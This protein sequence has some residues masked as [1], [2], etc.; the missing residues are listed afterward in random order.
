M[1]FL[2][3]YVLENFHKLKKKNKSDPLSPQSTDIHLARRSQTYPC[4]MLDGRRKVGAFHT[5]EILIRI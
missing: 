4:P 2:Y 3:L 1:D 5:L